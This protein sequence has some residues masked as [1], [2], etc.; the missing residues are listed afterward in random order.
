MRVMYG[1]EH[2]ENAKVCAPL[3]N[4]YNYKY[5]TTS[6]GGGGLIVVVGRWIHVRKPLSNIV[7]YA[8]VGWTVL[9]SSLWSLQLEDGKNFSMCRPNTMEWVM[10]VHIYLYGITIDGAAVGAYIV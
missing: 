7:H 1:C 4:I 9:C 6:G 2:V 5:T 8:M 3:T 10:N